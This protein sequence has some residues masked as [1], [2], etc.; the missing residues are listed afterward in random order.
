MSNK[1]RSLDMRIATYDAIS[2]K[3]ATYN[4]EELLALIEKAEHIGTSMGGTSHLLMLEN[5][6]I[7]IKKIPLTSLENQ[8]ENI[9]STRNLFDL[10]LC[11]QYGIGSKGFGAWRE[12]AVH[13]MTT[14]WVISG[15][16]PT[17]PLMYHNRVLPTTLL[18]PSANELARLEKD[19][20]YWE[21]H[22]SIRNR[23]VAIQNATAH[24]V[25]F[26]EYIPSNLYQWLT[27]QMLLDD[28]TADAACKMVEHQLLSTI[29]FMNSHE[30]LHFDAHFENILTDG[31]QLYFTD[32]GLALSSHFDL[33]SNELEF[34]DLHRQYDVVSGLVNLLHCIITSKCG[35]ENWITS[36][37]KCAEK[38]ST[39]LPP[40]AHKIVTQYAPIALVMDTFYRNLQSVS[41]KTPYPKSDLEKI[42]T[43][44]NS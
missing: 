24:I 41:K 2:K 18:K 26:L 33:S 30:V 25:L 5:T 8:T 31:Q 7:F 13:T 16:C 19:V 21:E 11:Y 35:R 15:A 17:F 3:L 37:K 10:P 34:F 43:A 1:Y 28:N 23:L 44:L 40:A 4:D 38:D 6:P 22:L 42:Y 9:Y 29:S 14:D 12:L 20:A 36:M 27:K 39:T 32:F